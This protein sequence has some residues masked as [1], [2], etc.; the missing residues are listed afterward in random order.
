MSDENNIWDKIDFDKSDMVIKDAF[1]ETGEIVLKCV[2][3]L[4]RHAMGESIFDIIYT[5]KRGNYYIKTRAAGMDPKPL[6]FLRKEL[7]N[8]IIEL[9]DE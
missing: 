1:A 9:K 8:K 5:D 3:E 2:G 4:S 7:I 6:V